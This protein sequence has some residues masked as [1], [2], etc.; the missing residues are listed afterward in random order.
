MSTAILWFRRDLRLDDNPALHAA[1]KAGHRV[2]PVY[3]H[4]PQDDAPW[5]PGA[6]SRWWLHQ[7]LSA[8]RR[9]LRDAGSDLVLRQGDTLV[10]LEWLVD[11]FGVEAVFWNRLYEPAAIER[12]T[13]IKRALRNRGILVESHNGALLVEPWQVATAQGDPY[14]VFTPFWK[15][16]RE[17]IIDSR[18]LPAP[19][20]LPGIPATGGNAS[21]SLEALALLP[22]I[23]W[24]AAF[25]DHWRPGETGAQARWAAFR[26]ETLG[27]YREAR[28]FPGRDGTSRLSSHLHFGEISP[29]RMAADILASDGGDATDGDFYLR[30]LGW[31]EFSHHLLYHFPHTTDAPL[32]ARFEDFPWQDD[33]DARCAW[34]QGRTG[35]PIVDAGMRQLWHA[36]WMHNR[37]RMIVASLLTKNLREHWLHGARWFWD[38]LLDADL[39]NNTLGWQWVAGSGADAAPYFRIFNPVTQGERFDPEGRFVAAW[40]PELGS[41]PAKWRHRP[42]EAPTGDLERAGIAR[43][44]VYRRP[45]VDLKVTREA[46]LGAYR[47]LADTSA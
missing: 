22:R 23:P 27:G 6:A 37:L 19:D 44:S 43:D 18:P 4:A 34:Q 35:I 20:R 17:R 3:I 41:L 7:A 36:G 2:L 24:D 47:S 15:R 5:V 30:E 1:L 13:R 25:A 45:L 21:I 26:D 46:A 14:K 12:D 32:N 10:E 33:S 29:R 38:T 39:A 9:S 16:A 28:D 31:R 8:L 42:W 40:V 11:A